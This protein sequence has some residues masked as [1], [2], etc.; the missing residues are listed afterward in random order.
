MCKTPQKFEI[1]GSKKHWQASIFAYVYD[2][3]SIQISLSGNDDRSAHIEGA[4]DGHLKMRH[5]MRV[6]S[7]T[8]ATLTQKYNIPKNL[9]ILSI[10]DE[11][12]S[13]KVQYI[14]CHI[15]GSCILGLCSY[16]ME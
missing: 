9:G 4:G 12:L 5:L 10:D 3:F 2:I 13:Y 15:R 7:Y 6:R 16:I 1:F 11:G 14:V 8:V